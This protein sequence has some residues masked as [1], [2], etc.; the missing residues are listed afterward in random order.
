MTAKYKQVAEQIE[1]DIV[2][3][4]YQHTNKL[5]TEDEYATKYGIS[6]NTVRKAIEILV[7]K[8]YVYQVQG[9]GVFVRD[10][11]NSDY[12]NLEKLQGL[13]SDFSGRK[14]ET[15]VLAFEQT[16]ANE[17]VAERMKCP[18]GT[19]VYYVKR[20]RLVDDHPFS[21]EDSYFRKS[22]VIY[23]DENII[24]K[25]IYN[26]LRND[27]K[28][29]IGFAD[30][31]IYADFLKLDDAVLLELKEDDPALLVDNTVYLTNGQIF[32]VSRATHHFRHVK[33]L[34]VSNIKS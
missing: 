21:V 32:D 10:H 25:S 6:R 24:Q 26:Y 5:L 17:E 11:Y 4:V 27:Q 12:V 20:L 13:T 30:R 23:L 8:G 28:L 22:L 15:R 16:T 31:V 19:P 7:N 34:K 2:N 33:M 9:S 1:T 14:V 3:H 18:V 29:A